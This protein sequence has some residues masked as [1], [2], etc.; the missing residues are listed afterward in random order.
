MKNV[1]KFQEN[2]NKPGE[3]IALNDEAR[4]VLVSMNGTR[5]QVQESESSEE[6]ILEAHR[7]SGVLD[8]KNWT[9][10]ETPHPYEQSQKDSYLKMG[11]SPAMAEVAARGDRKPV[12]NSGD[13]LQQ[14]ADAQRRG[15][16]F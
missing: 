6:Q 10:V 7:R 2:P 16:G 8:P 11:F 12:T 1:P 13:I 15:F 5:P 4:E 9:K 3:L 14:L